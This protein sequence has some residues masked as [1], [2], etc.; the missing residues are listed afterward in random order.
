MR[1]KPTADKKTKALEVLFAIWKKRLL[2]E[3]WSVTLQ[4]CGD[5]EYKRLM[6]TDNKGDGMDSAGTN[7]FWDQYHNSSILMNLDMDESEHTLVHELC[8]LVTAPLVSVAGDLADLL[9][10]EAMEIADK[11]INR[12]LEQVTEHMTKVVM[13]MK[14]E[15]EA[16]RQRLKAKK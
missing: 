15:A 16:E 6:H 11:Q 1:A 8:H 5:A 3:N 4:V 10:K 9:G 2:L 12:A 13:N 14:R 7:K